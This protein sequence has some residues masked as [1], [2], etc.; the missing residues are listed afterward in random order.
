VDPVPDPLLLKKSGSAWICSQEL[1]PLDHGGPI[2]QRSEMWNKLGI[3]L[4]MFSF[5]TTAFRGLDI[6]NLRMDSPAS[7]SLSAFTEVRCACYCPL[8]KWARNISMQACSI[9]FPHVN[10]TYSS[11]HTS[12]VSGFLNL[13]HPLIFL[14]HSYFIYFNL[15]MFYFSLPGVSF[16]YKNVAIGTSS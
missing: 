1:W 10:I 12:S 4:V 3:P 2:W 11:F 6:R 9:V 15:F 16:P 13:A 8:F 7:P 5:T 14:K